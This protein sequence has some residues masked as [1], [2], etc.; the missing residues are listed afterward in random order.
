[1]KSSKNL[2]EPIS[3]ETA[4]S[5]SQSLAG[6]SAAWNKDGSLIYLKN[7]IATQA[8]QGNPISA[9]DSAIT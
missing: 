6:S 7:S 9:A 3:A 1:M 4:I 8:S 5:G 2:F